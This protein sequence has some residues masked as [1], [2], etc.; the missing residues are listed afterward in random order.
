MLLAGWAMTAHAAVADPARELEKRA[1][2]GD[3]AAMLQM[4]DS[5]S[6]ITPANYENAR[7]AAE[8]YKKAM[9]KGSPE[10]RAR[11]AMLMADGSTGKVREKDA[12]KAVAGLTNDSVA[13][14]FYVKGM[15]RNLTK[16]GQAMLYCSATMG[17]PQALY[18]LA[19]LY[20]ANR[21]TIKR[22]WEEY[23]LIK[24][25]QLMEDAGSRNFVPALVWVVDAYSTR[26]KEDWNVKMWQ[27]RL[28]SVKASDVSVDDA[29]FAA[30]H[31]DYRSVHIIFGLLSER[32][33]E[34]EA[35]ALAEEAGRRLGRNAQPV[36]YS[37]IIA[38]M[39]GRMQRATYERMS[40]LA[41]ADIDETAKKRLLMAGVYLGEEDAA[42]KSAEQLFGSYPYYSTDERE[43]IEAHLKKMA[44][45]GNNRAAWLLARSLMSFPSDA[46]RAAEAVPY[47]RKL[48]EQGD[49]D[50]QGTLGSLYAD[51]TGVKTDHKEARRWL[52][53]A[54][55]GGKP[56]YK[57]R[58]SH[59]YAT[60]KA[61]PK[62]APKKQQRPARPKSGTRF[63]ESHMKK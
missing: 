60:P 21:M 56:E 2:K 43:A 9:A 33:T 36:A 35:L 3:I 58:Y 10:A 59:L 20:D 47:L 62:A 1:R 40:E 22:E 51:G 24:A 46:P 16:A 50:A 63:Q 23:N 5:Y 52:D 13:R 53:K 38:N 45:G 4:G 37:V 26:H 6:G 12:I 29:V 49:A 44:A 61:A 32:A 55:A 30:G 27:S 11:Y 57:A 41:G 31:S 7:R 14:M 39:P 8:W 17:Y 34:A 15:S 18:E 42:L 54:A 25:I 28:S 19:L 48:A